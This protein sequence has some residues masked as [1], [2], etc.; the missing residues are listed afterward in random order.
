MIIYPLRDAILKSVSSFRGIEDTCT[1]ADIRSSLTCVLFVPCQQSLTLKPDSLHTEATNTRL[2]SFFSGTSKPD[3]NS[4]LLPI[5]TV[6]LFFLNRR[7]KHNA[8]EASK[9]ASLWHLKPPESRTRYFFEIKSE[10]ERA[11]E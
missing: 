11:S 3:M 8:V 6:C 9:Q 2:K 1:Q 7:K 10:S 4:S 5:N